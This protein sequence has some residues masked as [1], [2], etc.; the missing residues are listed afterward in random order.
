MSAEIWSLR[1]AVERAAGVFREYEQL[2]LAKTPPDLE[3]AQRN[4]MYAHEMETALANEP[5]PPGQDRAGFMACEKCTGK[6]A[7]MWCTACS[8]NYAV[9]R[10]LTWQADMAVH[11]SN[12]FQEADEAELRVSWQR[13]VV[14]AFLDQISGLP[15][16]AMCQRAREFVKAC[17]NG[18][19]E[20]P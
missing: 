1:D 4:G 2:H 6:A 14:L 11:W 9:I 17:F 7:K 3:K 13:M 20:L 16:Y 10:R 15:D 5:L 19:I 12:L 18:T 8:Q